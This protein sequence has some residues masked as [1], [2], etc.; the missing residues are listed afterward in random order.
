MSELTLD[1]VA[2]KRLLDV[3]GGDPE[4]FAELKDE[5][6]ESVP[7]IIEAIAAAS[8][9]GDL[10]ALR[11]ASHSLKGNAREFGATHLAELCSVL[12]TACK[13]GTPFDATDQVAAIVDAEATARAALEALE[14]DNIG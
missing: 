8:T 4:D 11:V 5:Y 9:S 12:E 6:L 3:I 14:P 1:M 13:A 7:E 10:A 2:L